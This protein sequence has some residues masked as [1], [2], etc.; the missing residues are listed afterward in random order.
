MV[1]KGSR[2]LLH[3]INLLIEVTISK[4]AQV[5]RDRVWHVPRG[6]QRLIRTQRLGPLL[7][8]L[9]LHLLQQVLIALHIEELAVLFLWRLNH[10]LLEA[11]LF[12]ELCGVK[13][14]DCFHAL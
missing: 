2:V 8:H 1:L 12:L 13:L 9:R 11:M 5:W 10:V 14:V 4:A 3:L 7:R 6:D